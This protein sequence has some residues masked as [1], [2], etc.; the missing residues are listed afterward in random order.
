[1]IPIF[2][3]II[4]IIFIMIYIFI[5]KWR[6]ESECSN[7]IT[8]RLHS[9]INQINV[10]LKLLNDKY[11]NFSKSLYFYKKY[12]DLTNFFPSTI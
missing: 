2:I 9:E 10:E 1:M 7:N 4:T 3:T 8:D 11:N 6:R 12:K 5:F